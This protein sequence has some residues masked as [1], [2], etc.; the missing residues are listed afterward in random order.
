M[1]PIQRGSSRVQPSG[2]FTESYTTPTM[3]NPRQLRR[4]LKI[5]SLV[6]FGLL[7]VFW[8]AVVFNCLHGF[9][10]DG[11]RG[12]RNAFLR[13][14]ALMT[15]GQNHQ[16]HASNAAVQYGVLALV[17]ILLGLINRRT[18]SLYAA[19]FFGALRSGAAGPNITRNPKS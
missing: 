10:Q 18:I 12:A 13:H 6:F 1:Q 8:I 15:Y 3:N 4:I 14:S 9:W 5:S 16:T 2:A 17:T 19:R 11:I 7:S